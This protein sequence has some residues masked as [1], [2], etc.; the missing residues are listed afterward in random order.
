MTEH[1]PWPMDGSTYATE[2]MDHAGWRFRATIKDGRLRYVWQRPSL[3][4]RVV[5]RLG[6]YFDNQLIGR[7]RKRH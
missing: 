2:S 3:W 5:K 4:R 6:D 7:Y 1:K